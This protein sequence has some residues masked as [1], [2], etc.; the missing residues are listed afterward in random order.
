MYAE[1]V[2]S[3]RLP[4][5][6]LMVAAAKRYLRMLEMAADP[7]N[8][9]KFEPKYVV[10]YC[11]FAERLKHFEGG[12]W[13]LNQVNEDGT[14][15]DH[16]I[17]EPWQVWQE[18]A[19]HGFRLRRNDTRLVK[20]ALGLLPRKNTKSFGAT[21][22]VA[23]ELCCS[24]TKG[25]EIPIAAATS[26]QADQTLFGD[27]SKMIANDIELQEEFELK[28][29]K[30]EI[31]SPNGKCFKLSG[32][33]ERQDGL[34][35]SLAI[36]EEA[37]GGAQSVYDVVHSA[38]GARPNQLERM[39]TT[40]GRETTGPA[41]NL[42]SYAKL[43][44]AGTVEDWTFFAA[45][46]Q[47]DEELYMKR[48]SKVIDW[49]KLL[50]DVELIER[51]NPMIDISLDRDGLMASLAES[52]HRPEERNNLAR[53][54]FNIWIGAGDFLVE[55]EVWAACKKDK[56]DDQDFFRQRCWLG[57]D[58]ATTQDMCAIGSIFELPGDMLAIF[59]K[60]WL[61]DKSKLANDPDYSGIISTWHESGQLTL[62]PGPVQDLEL[63]YDELESMG[64]SFDVQAIGFDPYQAH[65]IKQRCFDHGLPAFTYTN[66][67]MNFTPPTRDILER[68]ASGRLIHDGNEVLAWNAQNVKG[69]EKDNGSIMPRREFQ[70]SLKKIDGFVAIVM[71]NGL[72]LQPAMAEAYKPPVPD[73]KVDPY[74]HRGLIGF[75]E[76][77]SGT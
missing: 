30:D 11:R 43:I 61:P 69:Q 65:W 46:F 35:P 55:P 72:R 28:I 68:V 20:T 48:D 32:I 70:G 59:A 37:H 57:V 27:I 22:A 71:A 62:V 52:K 36:Y 51:C 4:T 26:K 77:T 63:I 15:N 66:N 75:E 76:A 29:T 40:A 74:S 25:A 60:F 1:A 9:F 31:N 2:A 34:N 38:I 24:G 54:R 53:T 41:W 17:L 64:T 12:N 5:N 16:V 19:I 21:V 49:Q 67:A 47:L 45:I 8:H 23:F 50:F 39:I 13:E 14:V 7:A 58:L 3:E 6:R 56:L 42:L 73:I 44:L 18:S 33:A 10:D